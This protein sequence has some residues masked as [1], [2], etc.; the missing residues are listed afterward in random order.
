M[1]EIIAPSF[2]AAPPTLLDANF[3]N[4]VI[5]VAVHESEGAMGFII[6]RQSNLTLYELLKDLSIEPKIPDQPVLYGGPVGKNSGFVLYEHTP[7][8]PITSGFSL[9][10]NISISPSRDLLEKAARGE[11]PGRFELVL[12]YA[13]WGPGQ[14]ESELL[15]GAWLHMP[16]FPEVV[17]DVPV[18]ERWNHAFLQMGISPMR[19]VS[20]PG[21]AQA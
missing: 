14:L 2:L 9:C 19:F 20:V 7:G 17:F 18:T 13:G 10:D 16:V 21:G 6:S 5:A 12:G 11:M 1:Q 15:Q 4:A 8:D 3:Q